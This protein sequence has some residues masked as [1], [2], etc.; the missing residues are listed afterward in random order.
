MQ[1]TSGGRPGPISPRRSERPPDYNL[2]RMNRSDGPEDRGGPERCFGS[3]LPI[4]AQSGT[5]SPLRE[6]TQIAL[7][8]IR[9]AAIIP[10]YAET[11]WWETGLLKAF[12][13]HD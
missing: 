9:A 12:A 1:G 2:D 11:V 8:F 6:V 7:R 10:A 5:F 3:N 4:L 13:C